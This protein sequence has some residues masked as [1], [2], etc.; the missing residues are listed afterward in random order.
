MNLIIDWLGQIISPHE[1]EEDIVIMNGQ[2]KCI[3]I[4]ESSQF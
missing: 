1:A 4:K 3:N 2:Y